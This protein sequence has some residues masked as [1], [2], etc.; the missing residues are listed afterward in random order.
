MD[1]WGRFMRCIDDYSKYKLFGALPGD[2]TGAIHIEM[3]AC[4]PSLRAD[5]STCETDEAK[6]RDF[7]DRND[8]KLWLVTNLETYNTHEY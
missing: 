2:T 3:T 1:N 8:I 6:V 4:D 7:I 5:P